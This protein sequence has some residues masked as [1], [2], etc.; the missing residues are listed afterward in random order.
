LNPAPY[1]A[2]RWLRGGHVGFAAG[3]FPGNLDWLPQRLLAF[4][5]EHARPMR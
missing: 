1:R 2:P 3:A 4:F 5:N